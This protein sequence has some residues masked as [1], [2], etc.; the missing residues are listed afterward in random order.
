[1]HVLRTSKSL[2][3]M[4]KAVEVLEMVTRLSEVCCSA[5][6]NE[7]A[8]DLLFSLIRACNRSLPHIELLHCILRTLSNVAQYYILLPSM[9]T[10]NGVEVFLDL[11]QMFRDKD[12]VFCLT[13]SLLERVVRHSEELQVRLLLV[14]LGQQYR[15][16]LD[17]TLFRLLSRS[18]AALERT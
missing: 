5:F 14:R 18:F 8:P 6:A 17:L 13:V 7:G 15:S 4:L 9:A 3:E 1:L 2:S 12:A 10:V 16:A 11:V